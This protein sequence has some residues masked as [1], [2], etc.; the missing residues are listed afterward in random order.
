[1]KIKAKNKRKTGS[2]DPYEAALTDIEA[3][4]RQLDQSRE[5]LLHT[6]KSLVALRGDST[7]SAPGISGQTST[8]S[9]SGVFY[10]MTIAEAAKTFLMLRKVPMS[11]AEILAGLKAGGL[12]MSTANPINNVASVL[13]RR[14]IDIGDV[15]LVSR[16]IWGLA[17]WN[18]KT[19]NKSNEGHANE[20]VPPSKPM[21]VFARD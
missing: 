2:F 18:S 11:S 16:G 4:L 19:T 21:P 17:E 12:P 13:Y 3:K 10:G 9:D 15:I 8:F 5:E 1:M 20:L 6:K 14:R 7:S